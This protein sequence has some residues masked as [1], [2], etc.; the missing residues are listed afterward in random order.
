MRTSAD[1]I[2]RRTKAC[3]CACFT[4]SDVAGLIADLQQPSVYT[5]PRCIDTRPSKPLTAITALRLDGGSCGVES[6]DCSAISV[7]FTE[8]NACQFNP[9]APEESSEV[10]GISQAQREGCRSIML[11]AAEN[12]GLAC[13]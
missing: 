3:D 1:S 8:D 13:N 4:L 5:E 12:A 10:Q 6:L 2:R 9:I 11:E 7:A